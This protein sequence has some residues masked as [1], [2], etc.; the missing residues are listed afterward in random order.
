MTRFASAGAGYLD[1][2]PRDAVLAF[3]IVHEHHLRLA[4]SIPAQWQAL[5][6]WQA[7]VEMGIDAQLLHDSL[8]MSPTERLRELAERDALF[9]ALHGVALSG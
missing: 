1:G 4:P 6:E 8:R 3:G 7:L 5:P 9:C 2:G